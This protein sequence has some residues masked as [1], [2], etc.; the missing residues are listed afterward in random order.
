MEERTFLPLGLDGRDFSVVKKEV[1]EVDKIE[2]MS[3]DAML[4][5]ACDT[6]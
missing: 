6:P 3:E 1:V 5:G 2:S 4:P